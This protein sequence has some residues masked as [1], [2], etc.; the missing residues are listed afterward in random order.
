MIATASSK[1]GR[2]KLSVLSDLGNSRHCTILD[3]PFG[4]SKQQLQFVTIL[5]PSVR[6]AELLPLRYSSRLGPLAA[7]AAGVY[8]NSV[9]AAEAAD[10]QSHGGSSNGGST[11][12]IQLESDAL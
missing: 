9:G 8:T 3:F 1:T 5:P 6:P 11:A 2:A 10:S 4:V 7:V 12:N